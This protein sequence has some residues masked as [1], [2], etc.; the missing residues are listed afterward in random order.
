M[1]PLSLS[2]LLIIPCIAFSQH[3]PLTLTSP[4]ERITVTVELK[5]KL[6]YSI[7]HENDVVLAP[8][9]IGM[10]LSDGTSFGDKPVLRKSRA[11]KVER[12]VDAYFYKKNK[13]QDEFNELILTF[14]GDYDV[15]FRAYDA[16]VAYRFASK[17]K[18]DFFIENELAEFAFPEDYKTWV[19]Y[20]NKEAGAS[21][22]DQLYN[23]FE[24]TYTHTTL[25]DLDPKR[26]AFLPVLVEVSNGKK[27]CITEADLEDYPGMYLINSDGA[28]HFTGYFARYPK[29]EETGGHNQLQQIVTQR[30]SYIARAK[31]TRKFPW[32]VAIISSDDKGLADSD[33]VYQLASPSRVS[34]VSWIKPGKVAWDWWNDWN[35][36]GVNFKSGVNTETYKHYIDFAS[37]NKIEYVILDEGWAVNLKADLMQIV[38]EIDLREILRYAKSK[39][40]D[41]I[42]WAGYNAFNRDLEGVC[43]HYAG[44]GVKGFKVDFMD[45]DDQPMVN[46]Y[47]R[48]AEIAAKYNLLL[49]FHGAFKPTGLHR[50]YPNVINFEG[51]HGLEQ[52]KWQPPTVDQVTYDVTIPFIRMVAGPMDYTQG[53][54]RNS[55]KGSYRPVYSEPMSQGTRSRQ[56]A[57]Y[58]IFEAPLTMLCDNPT[59]YRKEPDMTNFISSMPTVWDETRS[60]SGKV[61][62]YVVIARKKGDVWYLGAMTNWDERTLEVDLSFLSNGVYKADVFR[63]GINAQRNAHDYVRETVDIS[64]GQKIVLH[65][66]SGGGYVARIFKP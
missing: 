28:N 46:F 4:D 5:D 52:M 26:L 33:L 16:G 49:D 47:Y 27:I 9:A 35:I 50:T 31:G 13:I 15:I 6:Y 21:F 37:E 44:L 43:K 48:A 29:T 41:I 32:R 53:A 63:D 61:G 64:P 30:E 1:K 2:L 36:T 57:E 45:R 58:V 25:H 8:S 60:I 22:E 19:P 10:Q 59:N 20:V 17:K 34:D 40:V 51:V 12:I 7:T 66:A 42:L 23:S 14:K 18:K 38:P 54:T 39:N 65:L 62:E 3:Q 55:T 24:N 56:L 11:N